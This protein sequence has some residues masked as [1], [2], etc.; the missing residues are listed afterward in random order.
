VPDLPPSTQNHKRRWPRRLKRI[1]F[2]LTPFAIGAILLCTVGWPWVNDV[3]YSYAEHRLESQIA[4]SLS[5]LPEI[6][7]HAAL[8]RQEV[9]GTNGWSHLIEGRRRWH[10]QVQ[11]H[12]V[13]DYT[14]EPEWV[15]DAARSGDES[16]EVWQRII[17]GDDGYFISPGNFEHLLQL[18]DHAAAATVD[19]LACDSI[20][21]VNADWGGEFGYPF[22]ST[23]DYVNLLALRVRI[24]AHLQRQGQCESEVVAL[25][26][27]LSRVT[28]RYSKDMATVWIGLRNSVLEQIVLPLLK[29]GALSTDCRRQ[30]LKCR[31]H[32]PGNDPKLWLNNAAITLAWIREMQAVGFAQYWGEEDDEAPTFPRFALHSVPG[33]TQLLEVCTRNAIDAQ[34]GELDLR[35]P[36]WVAG[37]DARFD[38]GYHPIHGV[39]G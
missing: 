22:P 37:Y 29:S 24:L 20:V 19:A 33:F 6:T 34:E 32:T 21:R 35:N 18:S 17:E 12:S 13:N 3:A 27:L 9:E 25:L 15:Y 10:A 14:T 7:D 36:D 11:K 23:S 16:E 2:A 5:Q 4:H 28:D 39:V 1:A 26:R 8:M 38:I 30:V 31:W